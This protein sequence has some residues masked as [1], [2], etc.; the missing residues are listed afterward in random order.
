[1]LLVGRRKGEGLYIG[2]DVRLKV[3]DV[4]KDG[5]VRLGIEAPQHMAVSRD[6]FTLEQ[7]MQ[8]QLEREGQAEGKELPAPGEQPGGRAG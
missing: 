1:M 4:Q 5:M 6:D 8:F 7:H 3:L 2:R